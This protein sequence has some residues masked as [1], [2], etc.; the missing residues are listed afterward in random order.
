MTPLHIT[1]DAEVNPLGL[2]LEKMVGQGMLTDIGLLRHGTDG[3]QASVGM[4]VTLQDGTQVLA[5]TTWKLFKMAYMTLA[6]SP[7]VA[8]E[9]WD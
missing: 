2:D 5:E 9:V 4:I 7:V 1:L 8:E 6:A 3:G